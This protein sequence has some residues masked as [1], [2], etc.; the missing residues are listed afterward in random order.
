MSDDNFDKGLNLLLNKAYNA[1][2][3]REEFRNNLLGKLK[4]QQRKNIN[5]RRSRIITLYSSF[6]AIAAVIV[7]AFLPSISIFNW[8]DSTPTK[9]STVTTAT[10]TEILSKPIN[11]DTMIIQPESTAPATT[12]LAAYTNNHFTPSTAFSLTSVDVYNPQTNK[13]NTVDADKSFA[14]NNGTKIRTPLGATESVN[15]SI[16]NGPSVMLDG[17]SQVAIQNNKFILEDGRA[18]VSLNSESNPVVLELDRQDIKLQPGAMVFATLDNDN[19]YTSSGIPAPMLVLLKGNA[20]T[21][22]WT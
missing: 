15:F 18:V 8:S 19:S 4:E 11:T 21:F 3:P 6:S 10:A 5:T 22:E 7:F 2:A 1:P 20:N 14:L 12:K 16:D 13:W 9:P 17:M